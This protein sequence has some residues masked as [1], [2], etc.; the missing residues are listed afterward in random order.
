MADCVSDASLDAQQ[1]SKQDQGLISESPTRDLSKTTVEQS[2]SRSRAI[3]NEDELLMQL[4][5]V[6]QTGSLA[7]EAFV[8]QSDYESNHSSNGSKFDNANNFSG[9]S[10]GDCPNGASFT[11]DEV[12]N[13]LQTNS[14]VQ[15]NMDKISKLYEAYSRQQLEIERLVFYSQI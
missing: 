8:Q 12:P 10:G 4:D 2:G 14:G 7:P 1:I 15:I 11:S 13:G 6:L 5:D 3:S 9:H